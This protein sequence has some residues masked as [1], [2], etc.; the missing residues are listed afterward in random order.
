MAHA[1][2]IPTPNTAKQQNTALSKRLLVLAYGIIGYTSGMCGLLWF[3]LAMGGLAPSGFGPIE[4]STLTVAIAINVS[5]IVLFGL[6]HSVMARPGFKRVLRTFMPEATERSS[7]L[8]FS[9]LFLILAIWTWQPIP[10]EVWSVENTAA[11]IGLYALYAL[12][13]SYLLVATFITNHFE[14][15][16]LRQIYLYVTNQPYT[17][18][19]FTRKYMYSYSRHPMMLGLLIGMWFVP[20]MSY[21]HFLM[22]S[23]ISI[24]VFIGIFFEERDLKKEFG[25]TY[26]KYKEDIAT[27]IPGMY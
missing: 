1:Y 21:S 22:A 10:G 11:I 19:P 6:Q 24:Y 23:L 14:L 13:W 7:F 20:T 2:A 25:K 27:L 9:G 17:K 4:S 26:K 18:I 3:I 12:G 16:G 15:M 8:L 5:L